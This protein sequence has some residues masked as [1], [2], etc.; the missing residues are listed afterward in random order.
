MKP[1][2]MYEKFKAMNELDQR[3]FFFFLEGF[4]KKESI[5]FA[6]AFEEFYNMHDQEDQDTL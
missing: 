5:N 4:Y 1:D 2:E 3:S 6:D